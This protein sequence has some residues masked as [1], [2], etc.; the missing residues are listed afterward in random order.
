MIK[1]LAKGYIP[2]LSRLKNGARKGRSAL[3]F[4]VKIFTLAD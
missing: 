1:Y 4:N 2:R 3:K